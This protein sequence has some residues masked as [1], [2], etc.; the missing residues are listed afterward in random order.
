[1]IKL[2][3]RVPTGR[4]TRSLKLSITGH[5]TTTLRRG[6]TSVTV[7]LRGETRPEVTVKVTAKLKSG[8]VR[9]DT[10]TYKTCGR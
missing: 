10:R 2:T 1:V 4:T 7:D 9:T 8:K 5:K 3:P 6:I